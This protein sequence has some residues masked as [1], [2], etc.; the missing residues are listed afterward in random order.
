MVD[1]P[2][3]NFEK[4]DDEVAMASAFVECQSEELFDK[5]RLLEQKKHLI[6]ALYAYQEVVTKYPETVSG[7]AALSCIERVR[8][9]LQDLIFRRSD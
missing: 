8:K 5:G 1:S 9:K 2:Q 7:E 4:Q 3:R 6:E